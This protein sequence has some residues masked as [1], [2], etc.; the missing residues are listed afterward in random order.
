LVQLNLKTEKI[1]ADITEV[2]YTDAQHKL[3]SSITSTL[4]FYKHM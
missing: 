2:S 1:L 4:E 3:K